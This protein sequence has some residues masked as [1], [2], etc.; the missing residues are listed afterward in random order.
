MKFKSYIWLILIFCSV[1][2]CVFSTHIVGGTLSYVYNGGSSYTVTLN[3]YRDC[4]AGTAALPNSVTISVRGNNGATFSPSKD[5]T[6]NL[7]TVTPVSSNLPACSIPPNPLPCVQVGNYTA[8]VTNLPPAVGGYHLYFQITARNL[9]LSNINASCNCVGESFYAYIPNPTSI[10]NE[11]FTLPNGT[12]VDNGATAW[13]LTA[14]ATPPASASVSGNVFQIQGANNAQETWTSQSINIAPYTHGVDLSV[15]LSKSGTLSSNDS[16]L[17]YYKLNGGP[18]TLFST[19]GKLN[20]NFANTS[21]TQSN[22]VGFT[23]QIIIRAHFN[24]SS[25]A[26]KVF[27]FDNVLVNSGNSNPTF[28]QFPPLFICQGKPFTVRSFCNRYRW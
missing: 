18:L 3:L 24:S 20:G 12:T 2:F 5:I 6:M 23:L 16:I 19:N 11:D 8:T 22:L 15:D 17:V 10:W 4:G 13:S 7:G 28:N 25:T 26:S 14:G 21:A 1:P 9:S 27:N